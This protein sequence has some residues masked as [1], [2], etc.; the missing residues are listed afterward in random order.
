MFFS[1]NHN[2]YRRKVCVLGKTVVDNL[3]GNRDPV[4]KTIKI[5]N[6]SFHV[7]GVMKE[8]GASGW[9]NPDDQVFIP[10]STAMKRIFGNEF[11]SSISVQANSDKELD[12]AEA[13]V[14]EIIRK[15]HKIPSNKEP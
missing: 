6:V 7:L 15:Q 1:E 2:I 13:E 9:R 10:Y 8:K 4:G 14:T 3:F 5:K 11:L 12:E